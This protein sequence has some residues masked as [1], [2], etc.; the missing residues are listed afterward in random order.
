MKVIRIVERTPY[1]DSNGKWNVFCQV[2]TGCTYTYGVV[3]CDTMEEAFALKEG[4]NIDAE[5]FDYRI[6]NV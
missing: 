1:I 5:K 3:M 6:K 4:Q 2:L